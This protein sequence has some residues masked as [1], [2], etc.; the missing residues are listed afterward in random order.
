VIRED[1]LMRMVKQLA[2]FVARIAGYRQRGELDRALDEVERARTELLEL[3]PGLVD[4]IDTPT[5]AGLLAQAPRIRAAARLFREEGHVHRARGDRFTAT[6]CYRRAFELYLE[7]RALEPSE[8][9][10]TAAIL[11]L[12]REV[13]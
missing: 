10:D 9:E 12:S 4:A 8:E 13:Q 3:P 5:L 11:E 1:Y 2:A 7:A 6:L